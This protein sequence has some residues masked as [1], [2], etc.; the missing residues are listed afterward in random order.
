VLEAI[1]SVAEKS[2]S[3][4]MFS[5]SLLMNSELRMAEKLP[6]KQIESR[7]LHKSGFWE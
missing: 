5:M 2:F 7:L 4:Q 6:A 1:Y 3:A